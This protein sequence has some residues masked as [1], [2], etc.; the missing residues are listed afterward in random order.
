M[1]GVLLWRGLA[2]GHDSDGSS[3]TAQSQTQVATG[4][5]SRP[6]SASRPTRKNKLDMRFKANREAAAAE[7]AAAAAATV[8]SF[9]FFILCSCY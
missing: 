8:G 9:L 7:A 6:T 1:C 4:K 3:R 5:G 2:P